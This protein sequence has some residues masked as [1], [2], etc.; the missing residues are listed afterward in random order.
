MFGHQHFMAQ[1]NIGGL[2][3]RKV[4]QTIQLLATKVAPVVRHATAKS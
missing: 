1:M 4:S 2:P 3:D